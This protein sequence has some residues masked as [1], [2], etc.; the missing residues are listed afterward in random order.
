MNPSD[1]T[2]YKENNEIKSMG[3]NVKN[4]YA[5]TGLPIL[6]GGG[7]K[8]EDIFFNKIHEYSIPMSLVML[9]KQIQE[10]DTESLSEILDDNE[11][12]VGRMYLNTENNNSLFEKLIELSGPKNKTRKRKIKMNRF[13]RKKY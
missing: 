4:I 9:N 13:T 11:D 2:F 1:F 12:V 6:I 10:Y 5:Q 3:F 7:K 8:K